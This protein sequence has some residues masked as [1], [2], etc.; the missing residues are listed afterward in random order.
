MATCNNVKVL[1]GNVLYT[2]KF[3][4]LKVIKNGYLVVQDNKVVGVYENLPE[5]YKCSEVID[6]GDKMIIPGFV[7]LH[8]HA[9][10]LSNRG[11]G[12]DKELLPWLETYTFPEESKYSNLEYAEKAYKKVVKELWRYGTTRS[13]LFGTIHKDSTNILMDLL[14]KAGLG[15]YVG[16]VNMDRNSPDF[17]IEDTEKS[18]KDT[19]AWLEETHNKYDIVKPIVTPRFVP[20]CTSNLMKGLGDLAK[21]YNVP[22]QSHLSENQGEIA[23]VSEL[24]PESSFYGE[25][26]DNHGLFGQ[27]PT[28]MA[29]CIHGND[30]EIELMA[31]NNVYVAHSPHSNNNLSSGIAPIRKLVEK[32]VPVGLASDISGG[33]A[34]SMTSIMAVSA[35]VSRLKWL[36]MNKE[37][38]A[39]SAPELLYLATK[40]GGGFFGKVGSF[41]EGYEFDALVIDD[42]NLADL[43]PRTLEERL[44]RYIYLGDDR[45]IIERYVAGKKVE[46]PN[47]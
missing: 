10:Q 34:I 5:E 26:Y 20:T 27:Q 6:H 16:K 2:P 12:M 45:N 21:K 14:A 42:E 17:Y 24:H 38:A 30:A 15:A 22:V 43:N 35:Q 3:G 37:Y 32:G 36:E 23:W 7:D 9:P 19:E 13:V 39:L 40:G 46:E 33:H 29:H 18:L 4:E 47:F 41:E 11:L 8:F 28:I 25:V 1:K 31:K 44:E